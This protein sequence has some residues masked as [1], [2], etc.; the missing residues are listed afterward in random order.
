MNRIIKRIHDALSAKGCLITAAQLSERLV[1]SNLMPALKKLVTFEYRPKDVVDFC[2]NCASTCATEDKFVVFFDTILNNISLMDREMLLEKFLTSQNIC[3]ERQSCSQFGIQHMN[4]TNR[5]LRI[6]RNTLQESNIPVD[7]IDQV[8]RRIANIL[9]TLPIESV[10]GIH[11]NSLQIIELTKA[12][13]RI[14]PIFPENVEYWPVLLN[15]IE[16]FS[17]Y[18]HKEILQAILNTISMD[19]DTSCLP[20]DPSFLDNFQGATFPDGIAININNPTNPIDYPPPKHVDVPERDVAQSTT[21]PGASVPV[22]QNT[23]A[24]EKGPKRINT[25]A[26]VGAPKVQ[27]IGGV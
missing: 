23:V 14:L 19:W 18:S 6:Y 25:S 20:Y 2:I 13:A 22:L 16:S 4:I 12:M 3:E 26:K 1:N 24:S 7:N 5:I 8:S 9:T 11:Q 17:Y 10:C 15:L 21:S 27:K